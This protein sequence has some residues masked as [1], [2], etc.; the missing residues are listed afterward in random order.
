VKENTQTNIAAENEKLP[1]WFAP[2]WSTRAVAIAF[3][4]ILLGYLT[5]YCTDML[6][7]S[8]G[9]VGTLLLVSKLFDGVTDLV[10]GFIIDK[11]NTR[12]GKAR[13]YEISIVFAWIFTVLIFSIPDMAQNSQAV[14]VFILYTLINSICATF[15]NGS[16]AVYLA[17]SVRSPQNRVKVMS[18]NGVI[19]ML[20]SSIIAILLPQVIATT[21]A[22]KAGWTTIA[23]TFAV[24]LSLIGMLRFVFVKEIDTNKD[25]AAAKESLG[26]KEGIKALAKNKYIFMLAAMIFI[27]NIFNGIGTA[28]GT[29]YFKY[30]VGDIGLMSLVSMTSLATPLLLLF[31]PKLSQKLGTTGILRWGTLISVV[32]MLIRTI[33]GTNIITLMIGSLSATLGIVPISAMINIYLIEC[34]D[35]GEWKT[36]VRVEGMMSSVTSFMSKLGSG[37]ASAMVGLIMGIAG[38]NGLIQT[39]S[40]TTNMS[41]IALYNI[42]PL[43]LFV[44]MFLL[45][46]AYNIDKVMPQV[47]EELGKRRS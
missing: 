16:D 18:V 4:F 21:G 46:L 7:M 12:F 37:L 3:N 31:F 28:V 17:R 15:L 38:Y 26:F 32:G 22:A 2:A 11:T 39:Q 10:V 27:V 29:Y 40:S 5:F 19:L 43:V 8:A 25:E 33:G 6:G 41:I 36:H 42:I 20:A 14:M 34:M 45:T 24:P 35:F 44:L 23:L 1:W 47:K 30:I 13:P 9:L